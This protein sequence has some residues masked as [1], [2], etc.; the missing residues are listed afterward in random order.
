MPSRVDPDL[1]KILPLLPLRDAAT[2]TPKRA[3]EELVA[4]AESRKDVPL[5]EL[6]TVKDIT[7]DGAAGPIA[8]RLHATGST[9]SATV[10][11]FHGGGWV[12]GDLFT[13]E[14]QARTLALELGA[15]VVSV[16]YRRPPETPFPGAFED[17]LAATKWAAANLDKLGGDPVRLAVAGDSAGGNLAAAVAQASRNGGPRLAAQLLIYP[18]VDLAGN[19]GVAA[20]NA[21]FPSRQENAEGYFLTG[22]AMRWFAGQ[23]LPRLKDSEDPRAS[24]LRS[25]DLG[26]LPRAVICTAEFDPLRDEGEAYADALKRAG[27]EVAY[28]REPGMVHG[29]FGMGAASPA[30][31]AARQRATVAFKAMLGA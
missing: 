6:A 11:Y 27:V 4:L 18:A 31:D 30:A 2:L 25:A 24:P 22:D 16:D 5:P 10:V 15:V 12:A 20:E 23:Y 28:F 14:R 8:A 29:Y 17:C 1:E 19:Y 9:P 21:K 3:R 7:V 13:H 26:G